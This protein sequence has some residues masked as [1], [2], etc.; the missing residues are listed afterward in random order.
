VFYFP[1]WLIVSGGLL[2]AVAN[3]AVAEES[4]SLADEDLSALSCPPDPSLGAEVA[5]R[6]L[7]FAFT[8]LDQQ[9][10]DQMWTEDATAF[11]PLLIGDAGPGRLEGRKAI[12]ATFDEFFGGREASKEDVMGIV[13]RAFRV[14]EH[15]DVAVVSFVLGPE[16]DNRRTFVF[17]R[18][19]DGWRVWH[20]HASWLGD[21]DAILEA[22]VQKR[23]Q[24]NAGTK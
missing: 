6:R 9:C 10:F 12:L 1:K 23:V 7:L 15:G 4:A 18:E 8:R 14:D 2:F 16:R 22:E 19:S 3:A 21:F 24:E 17:R 11:L 20:H 13:P 5:A